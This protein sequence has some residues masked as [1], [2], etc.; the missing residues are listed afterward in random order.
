MAQWNQLV[1]YLGSDAVAAEEG[2]Y[3]EC[4]IECGTVG[5]HGLDFA[6]GCKDEYLRGKKVEL[7]GIEKVHGIWLRVIKNLFDGTEPVVQ[8]VLVF[9]V[10]DVP[11]LVFPVGGKPFL[12]H[13]VHTV[14]AY[15]YLYPSS[16]LAHQRD[17]QSLVAV[18]L[19]MVEPVAQTVGMTLVQLADGHVDVEAFVHLVDPYFG[20]EDDA[21]GQDI[22]YL[23]EGDM[24]VLHLVPDGEWIFYAGF[25]FV[26]NAH[27]VQFLAYGFRKL[28]EERVALCLGIC[29]F[30]FYAGIFLRMVVA[31]AEV[32]QLGL[33][34]VES[35]AVGKRGIDVERLSGYLVL[36]VGRL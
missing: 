18:S 28:G 16:L 13:L 25:D 4:K 23:V 20:R 12:C 5:R 22:V 24:L 31:E 36:L 2:V 32:F 15:L 19:G 27:L 10:L 14:G 30:V 34:F 8:F 29:Q 9:R 11:F 3:L 6:F 21:N 17:V 26:V 33:D 7:D 35:Q 1:V